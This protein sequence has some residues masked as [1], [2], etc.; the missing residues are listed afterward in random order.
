[1]ERSQPGLHRAVCQS[2]PS[3]HAA[4]VVEA[5][6]TARNSAL[7]VQ[8]VPLITTVSP[9][10][11]AC[12]VLQ[13]CTALQDKSAVRHVVVELSPRL[14]RLDALI[15]HEAPTM[16]IPPQTLLAWTAQ[17]VVFLPSWVRPA[18]LRVPPEATPLLG[19]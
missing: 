5:T 2:A 9:T 4:N 14:V 19:Q 11:L 18:A 10:L 1:M 6:S 12:F 8:Q 15:V 16:T 3:T 13:E 7:H 17:Q